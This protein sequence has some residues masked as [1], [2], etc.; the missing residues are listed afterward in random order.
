MSIGVLIAW[1]LLA[2]ILL[3]LLTAATR[4]DRFRVERALAMPVPVGHLRSQ[5]EDFH[6]WAAWSPWEHIDPQMQRTYSGAA[7]GTGAVYAWS[8]SGRA[9]AGRMEITDSTAERITIR[10]DFSK[11]FKASN[12]VE[13]TLQP[14]AGGTR[15]TWAMFGPSPFVSR[16]MGLF[17]NLDRMIGRDFEAGL[18]KLRQ[19]VTAAAA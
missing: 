17:F 8:G 11:P 13:F 7:S 4:P 10:I 14:E 6:A 1:A 19:V 16:L 5:L 3:V 15:V 9:G 12:T 2:L 18:S